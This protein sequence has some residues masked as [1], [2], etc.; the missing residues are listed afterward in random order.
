MDVRGAGLV[1]RT[2]RRVVKVMTLAAE[3]AEEKEL[4]YV[5]RLIQKFER[6]LQRFENEK[7]VRA[8][9]FRALSRSK[10]KGCRAQPRTHHLQA[11]KL[12][13]LQ[14]E[15]TNREDVQPL[16]SVLIH[17]FQRSLRRYH[18]RKTGMARFRTRMTKHE[19]LCVFG[20]FC[21]IKEHLNGKIF[22]HIEAANTAAL[23]AIL[24]PILN[25]GENDKFW[26][27]RRYYGEDLTSTRDCSYIK[28]DCQHK[29]RKSM[30]IT[31]KCEKTAYIDR[32]GRERSTEMGMLN[33]C[34]PR[35]VTS[36][37]PS[38]SAICK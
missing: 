21:I 32:K 14:V 1:A 26:Y 19:F 11:D 23:N 38:R 9:A 12:K 2:R 30:L 25:V 13:V 24:G 34:F 29:E 6:G 5:L 36:V 27:C 16:L 22:A 15:K 28:I 3:Q 35:A 8:A 20:G 33:V 18:L 37:K 4:K 31:W 17:L 7:E 10:K